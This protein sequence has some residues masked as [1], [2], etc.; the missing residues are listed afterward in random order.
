M[1]SQHRPTF[2]SPSS[3]PSMDV[4]SYVFDLFASTSA[5]DDENIPTNEDGNR[6][7]FQQSSGSYCVIAWNASF[8][9]AYLTNNC[10]AL[11][12]YVF[13]LCLYQNI[14]VNVLPVRFSEN[15]PQWRQH[16]H[17]HYSHACPK[18]VIFFTKPH[19][20]VSNRYSTFNC[21]FY[22]LTSS[23]SG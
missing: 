15:H 21:I 5:S 1:P 16:Y 10:Y 8:L 2:I 14:F 17:Y 12:L 20:S 22:I 18:H 13:F 7:P 23:H 4:F 3:S 9:I 11:L 6:N 19:F